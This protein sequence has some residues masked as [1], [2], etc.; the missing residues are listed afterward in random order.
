MKP[1]WEARADWLPTW[2][3][4]TEDNAMHIDYVRVYGCDPWQNC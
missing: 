2:N 3:A 4:A 1:F